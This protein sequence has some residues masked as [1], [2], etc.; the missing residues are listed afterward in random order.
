MI[1]LEVV[2]NQHLVIPQ[3]ILLDQMYLPILLKKVVLSSNISTG[4]GNDGATTVS[5][6]KNGIARF[7]N[8]EK[9]DH[10][11]LLAYDGYTGSQK[12]NF[13][14]KKKQQI[15]T[16]QIKLTGGIPWIWFFVITG[17]LLGVIIYLLVILFR[18]KK[19]E[20]GLKRKFIKSNKSSHVSL[21]TNTSVLSN[22]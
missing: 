21:L 12:L 13:D 7:S 20:D 11:V 8:V 1:G 3:N 9:G 17:V 19:K 10:K 16:M 22:T 2:V 5:S 15:L 6:D 14:G 4:T 18:K